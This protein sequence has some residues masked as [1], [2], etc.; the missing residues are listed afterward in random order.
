[1]RYR[2]ARF[3]A[4]VSIADNLCY[5]PT[6]PAGIFEVIAQF[7]SDVEGAIGFVAIIFIVE[8]QAHAGADFALYSLYG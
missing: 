4:F 6:I 3:F 8:R 1:M 7:E 2:R 5:Y